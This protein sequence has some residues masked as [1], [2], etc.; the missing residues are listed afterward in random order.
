M[1]W[2][3]HEIAAFLMPAL[4]HNERQLLVTV[5]VPA[6]VLFVTGFLIALLWLTPFTYYLLF[7]YVAAMGL[8]PYLSA[9]SFITFTLLYTTAFGVVFEVP[10]FVYTLT[11]L[12]LVKAAFWSKHWRGAIVACLIFGMVIT[13]DNS[14]ITMTLIAVPMMAL[15]FG[16]VY[17]ARRYERGV[18]RAAAV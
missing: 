10:V 18:A 13:P 15:Y 3:T 12:H 9:D 4:R 5:A 6:T 11:R 2:T 16:G 14:G 1:P 17:F 7:H 8:T